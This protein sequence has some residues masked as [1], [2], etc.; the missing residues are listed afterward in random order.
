MCEYFELYCTE[1]YSKNRYYNSSLTE[2]EDSCALFFRQESAVSLLQAEG[3]TSVGGAA[4]AATAA[5]SVGTQTDYRDSEA[6][7][8]PYTPEYVIRPGEQPELLTLTKLTWGTLAA[9]QTPRPAPSGH[10]P[11]RPQPIPPRSY[12]N[13][14]HCASER[15]IRIVGSIV[16]YSTNVVILWLQDADCRRAS[17]RSR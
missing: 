8:D 13:D 11:A 10:P 9:R 1:V 6:Q 7:T 15:A 4:I 5:R 2:R 17:R 14:V 16:Q 3:E 12:G